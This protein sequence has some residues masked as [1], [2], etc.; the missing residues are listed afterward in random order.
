MEQLSMFGDDFKKE[1]ENKTFI[2]KKERKESKLKFW[3][4]VMG[5]YPK[6]GLKARIDTP[7][8]FC[9]SVKRDA[10]C[11]HMRVDIL[12]IADDIAEVRTLKEWEEA[13]MHNKKVSDD[14]FPNTAGLIWMIPIEDLAPYL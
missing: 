2:K 3:K 13:C 6:E 10:Y 12:S 8:G 1:E 5:W 7:I 14:L 4:E 11:Y 9:K